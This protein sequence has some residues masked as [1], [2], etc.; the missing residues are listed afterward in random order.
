MATRK[1]NH[2]RPAL[3]RKIDETFLPEIHQA[4]W[5]ARLAQLHTAKRRARTPADCATAQRAIREHYGQRNDLDLTRL[6]LEAR[7]TARAAPPV[8][9]PLT[10]LHQAIRYLA[11]QRSAIRTWRDARRHPADC[12]MRPRWA[13]LWRALRL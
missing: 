3:R 10:W 12:R 13:D 4:R 9:S 5:A 7:R 2:I 1:P 11:E 8:P 6:E